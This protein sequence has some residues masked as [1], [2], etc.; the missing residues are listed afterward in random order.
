MTTIKDI[1]NLAGV[2][3]ATVSR[4]L[5]HDPSIRVNNET[6]L[7]IFKAAEEL[8][9][10]KRRTINSVSTSP[11]NIGIVDWY[12]EAALVNDPYYLYLMT[13]VE[14][15]CTEMSYNTFKILKI[16]GKY[17]NTVDLVPDGIIAI[18]RFPLSEVEQLQCI[19]TNIVFL[20]SS[21]DDGKFDSVLPNLALGAKQA[22][23]YLYHLGHRKI[24]Y[25]GGEV[26]NDIRVKGSDSREE[27][28]RDFMKKH[29]LFDEQLLYIGSKLSYQEGSRLTLSLLA[30]AVQPTA[31]LCGN[32]TVATGVLNVIEASGKRVPEDY[33][34]VGFNDLPNV[35]HLTPP[36]TTVRIPIADIAEI[37]LSI[38]TFNLTRKYASPQKIYVATSLKIRESCAP[39]VKIS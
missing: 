17:T 25:V 16:K 2:S 39:V 13:V 21:P 22:L 20:D 28:Y 3:S 10:T 27:Y 26:V 1:A 29:H 14:K 12:S 35:Q 11:M 7:R 5:N 38:L 19:T 24:A 31:I 30:A 34:I 23:E 32:D 37:A 8:A 36:L 15:H 4:V 9:Y 18:G 33:S 6:K